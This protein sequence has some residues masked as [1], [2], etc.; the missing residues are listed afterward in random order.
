MAR[1]NFSVPDNITCGVDKTR[2]AGEPLVCTCS[3]T[4]GTTAEL[5]IYAVVA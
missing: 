4:A 1:G 3:L 2:S 5:R